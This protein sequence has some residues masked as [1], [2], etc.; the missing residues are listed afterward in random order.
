MAGK[1]DGAVGGGL[2]ALLVVA[3]VGT[4][5]EIDMSVPSFPDIARELGVGG[6]AVQL[7]IT[8]N[9]L[10]YCLGAL[11]HGPLSD[12]F[13]RRPVMLGGNAVM[14]V[15]ALGCAIAPTIGLLL[16]ARFVQGIGAST[17][18]VLVFVIIGDRYEGVAA[19]RMYGLVNAAMSVLM[20]AAPPLGGVINHLVGWRG[21]YFTVCAITALS[22]LLMFFLLPET[23]ARAR[24]E[25]T[26][27]SVLAD[28][29]ALL[30]SGAYLAASLVPSLLFAAYLVFIAAS[31]F[32]YTS[33]FGLGATEF[34][35]TLLVVVAS[36]AIPS[37]F[38]T[39]LIPLLG[40]PA[41]A[42]RW[43][44][45]AVV[46][47]VLGFL[48][49][50]D[51]P[52]A[53]TGSVALFCAGFAV[54]YPVVF[55]RSMAVFPDRAGAAS[56]LTMGLRA[57]LVT[58]LTAVSGALSTGGPLVPAAVMAGAVASALLLSRVSARVS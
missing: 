26:A 37:A 36:F 50:G 42:V 58:L 12:R 13:G 47:G 23:R 1:I 49:L 4:I 51:G 22:L 16:A 5:V 52:V 40:G 2:P 7:T 29:R 30:G 25:V 55:A 32:L 48:L 11:C 21:N 18:V 38:A 34:A 27:R 41:G 39:R 53:A 46:A 3:L 54:C 57:L 6:A 19:L 24:R 31:S 44:L 56:S 15:G 28:Y 8:L 35:L 9:F 10:G 33:A 43:S 14:L 17:A 45:G 20:T